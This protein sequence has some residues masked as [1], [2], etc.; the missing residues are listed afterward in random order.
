MKVLV[1]GILL[2]LAGTAG[3]E[4]LVCRGNIISTQG[5]G[6]VARKHRF[7]VADVTGDDVQAV[8]EKC[9]KIALE[10]Q[11]RAARKNPGG[12]FT[13]SSDVELQ[14]SKGTERIEVRRRIQTR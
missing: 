5:E 8:L 14:C 6:I 3:A 13:A 4:E 11:G 10:R 12:N 2:L 1:V 7:E 9:R